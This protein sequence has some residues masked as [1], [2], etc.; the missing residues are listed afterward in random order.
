MKKKLSTKQI[1]SLEKAWSVRRKMGDYTLVTLDYIV[2]GTVVVIPTKVTFDPDGTI[3]KVQWPT[4]DM[5]EK[6]VTDEVVT[7]Q[8][9]KRDSIKPP[10]Q[11]KSRTFNT[12]D[13][14]QNSKDR[15]LLNRMSELKTMEKKTRSQIEEMK[16]LYSEIEFRQIFGVVLKKPK[17]RKGTK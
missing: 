2:N 16:A 4:K 7:V 10:T 9:P 11:T 14:I 6:M 13:K 15:E 3:T 8:Y 5:M 1:K 12:L 17:T